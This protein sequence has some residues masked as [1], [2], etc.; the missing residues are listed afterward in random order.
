MFTDADIEHDSLSVQQLVAKAEINNLDLVSLMVRLNCQSVWELLLIPAFVFFF[1]MLYPFPW[2]NDS[3]KKTAAAAG[4]CVLLRFSAY[5]RDFGNG[6]VCFG[7]PFSNEVM[8][9]PRQV[10]KTSCHDTSQT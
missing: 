3:H 10:I 8:R 1:Q 9:L 2:V 4:G 7:T 5:S 6:D